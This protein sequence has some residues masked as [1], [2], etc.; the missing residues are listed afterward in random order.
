M[1]INRFAVVSDIH[2]NKYALQVFMNYLDARPEIKTVLNL[3]DFLQLGPNPQEVFDIVVKDKRFINILGN[4]EI[5]LFEGDYSLENKDR[6]SHIEWTKA[7]IG[8]DRLRTLQNIPKSKA[9]ELY[10]KKFMLVHTVS[11]QYID[12]EE[13]KSCEYILMGHT[14]L[15]AFGS[16]WKERRIM[17]PGSVGY[18][19]NAVV[20][21]AVVEIGGDIINFVFKNI[22]YDYTEF[23]KD[24]IKQDVPEKQKILKNLKPSEL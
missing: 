13:L 12:E 5:E 14:H 6:I 24:L 11:E 2:A 4:N 22:K 18:T 19:P 21:F 15:Q 20:N 16:Y 8:S 23:Q 3:G 9:V 10:G 7:A 1:N 17:N